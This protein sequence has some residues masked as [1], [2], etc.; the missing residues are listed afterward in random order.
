M[1]VAPSRNA[2][3]YLKETINSWLGGY[4]E[5]RKLCII[6]KFFLFSRPWCHLAPF[7]ARQLIGAITQ[8]L[9]EEIHMRLVKPNI[10]FVGDIFERLPSILTHFSWLLEVKYDVQNTEHPTTLFISFHYVPDEVQQET[11]LDL[12]VTITNF[13]NEHIVCTLYKPYKPLRSVDTDV[14]S[15]KTNQTSCSKRKINHTGQTC[16]KISWSKLPTWEYITTISGDTD[17]NSLFERQLKWFTSKF[18]FILICLVR[19]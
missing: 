17:A 7:S 12:F 1:V 10:D 15:R 6:V 4:K 8:T 3:S 13:R 5:D 18:M 16:G 11:P 14:V 2:L 19:R 9:T